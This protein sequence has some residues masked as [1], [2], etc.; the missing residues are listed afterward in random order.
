ME[1]NQKTDEQDS[2]T[3]MEERTDNEAVNKPGG[4]GLFTVN[5]K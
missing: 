3:K 1:D 2:T 5:G 4:S